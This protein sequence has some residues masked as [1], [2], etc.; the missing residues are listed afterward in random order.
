MYRFIAPP[1]TVVSAY[2]AAE[3]CRRDEIYSKH[4]LYTTSSPEILSDEIHREI[5]V[6]YKFANGTG[7]PQAGGKQPATAE[8]QLRGCT[9][10]S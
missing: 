4:R 2:T 7:N 8:Q 9:V 6:A 10:S 5:H 1:D 3:R